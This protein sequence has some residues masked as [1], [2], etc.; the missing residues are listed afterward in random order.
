MKIQLLKA[1]FCHQES[2]KNACRFC[3]K[4][5]PVHVCRRDYIPYFKI[6]TSNFCCPLFFKEYL[7]P[8]NRIKKMIN[9]HTVDYHTCPSQLTS[10]IHPLIFLWTFKGSSL[11]IISL[12]FVKPGYPTMIAEKFQISGF[13]IGK[14]ICESKN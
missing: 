6:N 14:Y 3:M 13:K 8:Q 5:S 4:L 7:N 11:Q 12:I 1:I 2:I 10:R 9:E